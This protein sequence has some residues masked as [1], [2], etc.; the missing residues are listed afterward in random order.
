MS[1]SEKSL[2]EHSGTF[3]ARFSRCHQLLTLIAS[4][5]L[6]GDE[7]VEEAVQNCWLTASRNPLKFKYEGAFRGWLLRILI[8]EAL[9]VLRKK[10]SAANWGQHKAIPDTQSLQDSV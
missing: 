7:G 2:Q 10:Q 6:G 8:D 1:K 9:D 5:V 3:D 4:R